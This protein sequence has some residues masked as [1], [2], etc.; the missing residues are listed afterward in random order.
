MPIIILYTSPVVTEN[1]LVENALVMSKNVVEDPR[2]TA[3]T[4]SV[5]LISPLSIVVGKAP[6]VSTRNQGKYALKSLCTLMLL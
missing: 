2:A 6:E 1:V 4:A 5:M 3:L